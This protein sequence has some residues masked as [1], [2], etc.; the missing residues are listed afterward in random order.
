M[1]AAAII[2]RATVELLVLIAALV[3][4]AIAVRQAIAKPD[5][6][7]WKVA[8]GFSIALWLLLFGWLGGANVQCILD[9]LGCGH[10]GP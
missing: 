3:L 8:S 10:Y 5:V 4:P 6:T 7:D 2:A 9:P 1:T